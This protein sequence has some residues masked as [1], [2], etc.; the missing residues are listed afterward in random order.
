ML[1]FTGREYRI[2]C[3]APTTG[4]KGSSCCNW[5]PRKLFCC[6]TAIKTS[7]KCSPI[8]GAI[9]FTK[10]SHCPGKSHSTISIHSIYQEIMQNLIKILGELLFI[11]HPTTG[12]DPCKNWPFGYQLPSNDKHPECCNLKF[13]QIRQWGTHRHRNLALDLQSICF[14]STCRVS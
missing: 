12:C 10:C 5:L 3:D 1:T 8:C 11:S 9:L 6:W 2:W 4:Q 14:C 7:E 13:A